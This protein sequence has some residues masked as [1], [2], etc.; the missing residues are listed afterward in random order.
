MILENKADN[1]IIS[2][3]NFNTT[4]DDEKMLR[5]SKF[6]EYKFIDKTTANNVKARLTVMIKNYLK[7]ERLTQLEDDENPMVTLTFKEQ[8][9][10]GVMKRSMSLLICCMQHRHVYRNSACFT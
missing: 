9:G 10:T 1:V 5:E 3:S 2:E 7:L 6:A 8:K 4:D